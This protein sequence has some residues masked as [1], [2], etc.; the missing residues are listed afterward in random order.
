MVSQLPLI[1]QVRDEVL[2]EAGEKEGVNIEERFT[3][4]EEIRRKIEHG[5]LLAQVCSDI[6]RNAR[7]DNVGKYQSCMVLSLCL[8]AQEEQ[9]DAEQEAAMVAQRIKAFRTAGEVALRDGKYCEA[10]SAFDAALALQPDATT[11]QEIQP[12]RDAAVAGLAAETKVAELLAK[13]GASLGKE[14]FE[15][16]QRLAQVRGQITRHA[17]THSVGK[18]QSCMFSNV[19]LSAHR[20][21]SMKRTGSRRSRS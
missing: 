4:A 13:A 9:H 21:R 8:L 1:C 19:G 3:F 17:R 5:K 16:A 10:K 11:F 12:M 6:I 15:E 20:R 18:S 2:D 7:I 14:D